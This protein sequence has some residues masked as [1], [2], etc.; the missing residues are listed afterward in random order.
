MKKNKRILNKRRFYIKTFISLLL[1]I[2]SLFSLASCNRSYDE[3]EVKAAAKDLIERSV[4]FNEIYWGE[5]ISY[6]ENPSTSNGAY[7]EANFFDL[8]KYGFSTIEELKKMTE[9]VYSKSYCNAIFNAAF[10]SVSDEDEI[11]FFARYYQKYEDEEQKNPE[12]IMVYGY[13][14][15]LLPD[16]VEYLYETITVTHS[17]GEVVYI[18][19]DAI[20]TRSE[21]KIQTRTRR[22]ALIEEE[23]GWRLN[24]PSYLTYNEFENEYEDL[25][26]K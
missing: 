22:I 18:T 23:D 6:I 11:H 19:I 15:N 4:M 10:S 9:E 5:G 26:N 20:V 1:I 13:A 12:C 8:Q 3:E 14:E 24:G 25:N 7:H 16:K 2:T 17:K 21:D